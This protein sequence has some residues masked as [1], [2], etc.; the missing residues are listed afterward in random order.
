MISKD[1]SLNI[2]IR[3]ILIVV[4]S[5]LLGYF[6]TTGQPVIFSVTCSLI[7]IAVS[8]NLIIYLNSLNRKIKFFFDA[9]RNDDS[10][11]SFPADLK[12]KSLRELYQSMNRVNQQ[13]QQLK[14]ENRQQEQYFQTLLEHLATGIITFNNNG[15]ILQAN[16]SAK[17][18]LSTDVLTHLQ[19]IERIDKRLYQAIK[20]IG[21]SG[22]RLIAVSTEKGDTQLSLKATEFK[23]KDENI[24]ILSLQDIKKELDEKELESW[25]KLIK[26]L[27]HEIMNSITPITSLSESL[28]H[29]YCTE[30]GPVIPGEVNEKTI[31]TTIQ[32]LN[33]IREQGKGLMSFVE[34]YRKLTRIPKP[35]KK[36]FKVS[37]LLSRVHILYSSVERKNNTDLSFA[38]EGNDFDIFGDENLISQVLINLVK[39][40]F[41][42]NENN[43]HGKIRIL[44]SLDQNRYPEISVADNGPGIS[45]ENIEE[46]FIPF[47]TTH[48]NG[49]G[50]GLSISKQI[51][52]AH[53]G[54]LK[55]KSVPFKE[56]IFYMS[57][58]S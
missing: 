27:M 53:G 18:L 10:N 50:I 2:I 3:I 21:P 16:S 33:V 25:M 30:N 32:G 29:F 20:N 11:L 35:D 28:S 55:V 9:V 22:R 39:N 52:K 14:I 26:V 19:Q 34:S 44:A 5:A 4:I 41:E 24:T 8:V 6:L 12:N 42:A 54:S 15:F 48:E 56:T 51:M 1:L 49:S 37:D 47:F 58:Q 23:A 43:P 36:L 7:I 13:I 38:V 17:K 45:N 31:S 40:A 57:F 46:I